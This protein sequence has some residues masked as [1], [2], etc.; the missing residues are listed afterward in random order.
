MYYTFCLCSI[1]FLKTYQMRMFASSE[2]YMIIAHASP[3]CLET[4]EY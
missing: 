1:F 4:E 2:D 3:H